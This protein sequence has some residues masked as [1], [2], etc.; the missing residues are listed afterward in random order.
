MSHKILITLLAIATLFI[1]SCKTQQSANTPQ[2][3]TQE[4][5][6]QNE[7]GNANNQILTEDDN[8]SLTLNDEKE[9]VVIFEGNNNTIIF[10]NHNVLNLSKGENDTIVFDFSDKTVRFKVL[11]SV[12]SG[13]SKGMKI[14][15]SERELHGDSTVFV[16]EGSLNSEMKMEMAEKLETTYF[17]NPSRISLQ[18]KDFA[19]IIM[20]AYYT[21]H[22]KGNINATYEL[23]RIYYY[24]LVGQNPNQEMGKD[25]LK[26][27]ARKGNIESQELL[28]LMYETWD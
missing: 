25:L 2:F 12:S 10:E 20:W 5:K 23:G 13:F 16:Y 15:L 11:N 8:T 1:V 9:T 3:P 27:S 18:D 21:E 19:A 28:E 6:D 7:S 24:G 4:S 14:T 22:D 17:D 26:L